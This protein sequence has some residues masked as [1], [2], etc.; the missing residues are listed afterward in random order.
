M[1]A[2]DV[3]AWASVAMSLFS[4]ASVFYFVGVKLATLQV[5]VD[6]MWEFTLR[7]GKSEAVK[8]G[9]AVM[10]SP[11]KA[12]PEALKLIAPLA[13]ALREA[14]AQIGGSASDADLA[15][16]IEYRLGDRMLHEVCIPNRMAMG[17]CLFLAIE[18]LKS[19]QRPLAAPAH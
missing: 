7:R 3:A 14:F 11:V 15:A 10:N 4:L 8:D 6:T 2:T 5:K 13:P 18:Y 12:T 1:T 19:L 9:L 17:A 16:K